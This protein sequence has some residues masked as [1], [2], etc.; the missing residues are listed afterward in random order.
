M[1]LNFW[2][3]AWVHFK[4]V[5]LIQCGNGLHPENQWCANCY[6]KGESTLE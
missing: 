6:P 2:H 5:K 3:E 1:E 4:D